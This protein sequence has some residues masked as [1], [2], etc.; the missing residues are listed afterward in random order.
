MH[1]VR[2]YEKAGLAAAGTTDNKD[3]FVSCILRLLRAAAHH[4]PFR[5]GEQHVI[6]KNRV[7]IRLYILRAAPTCGTVFHAFPVFLRVLAL[8]VDNQPDND[9][10]RNAE[11]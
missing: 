9:R 3:I 2:L 4:Q 11:S 8:E 5:L 7:D 1:K 6:F 10:A